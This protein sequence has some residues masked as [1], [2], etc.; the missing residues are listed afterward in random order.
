MEWYQV[1][2]V[3]RLVL[4]CSMPVTFLRNQIKC[5]LAFKWRGI[6]VLRM[7]NIHSITSTGGGICPVCRDIFVGLLNMNLVWH[8]H[9]AKSC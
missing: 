3:M 7:L 1:N 8:A 4:I 5:L 6:E 9:S 2:K